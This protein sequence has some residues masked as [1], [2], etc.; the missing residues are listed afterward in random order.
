MNTTARSH[1]AFI[2]QDNTKKIIE[3]TRNQNQKNFLSRCKPKK[4][5]F[6]I[7][8][9]KYFFQIYLPFFSLTGLVRNEFGDLKNGILSGP[10]SPTKGA[11]ATSMSTS[12]LMTYYGRSMS[13]DRQDRI[14]ST[15]EDEKRR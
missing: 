13:L 5:I 1:G 7:K 10:N 3:K 14:K 11:A 2:Q 6:F 12:N 15:P 8:L 4:V 9:L